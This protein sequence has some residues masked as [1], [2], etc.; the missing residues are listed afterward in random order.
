MSLVAAGKE[1]ECV[2]E[3]DG[4]GKAGTLTGAFYLPLESSVAGSDLRE[5]PGVPGSAVGPEVGFLQG[6]WGEADAELRRRAWVWTLEV[7]GVQTGTESGPRNKLCEKPRGSW[8]AACTQRDTEV[9][10]RMPD[11]I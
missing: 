8:G 1:A 10:A 3:R 7:A 6:Q 9:V 4:A 2:G 11:D 5:T